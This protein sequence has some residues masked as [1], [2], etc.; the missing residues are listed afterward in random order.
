MSLSSSLSIASSGLSALQAELA[1]ASQ[2]V[3]NAGTAGYAKETA[4]VSSRTSGGQPGGVLTGLTG[5]VVDT[6]LEASLYAQNATVAALIATNTNLAPILALQG[7]TS[8]LPGI[9]GTLSD[10]VGNLQT[11]LISLEAD[12]TN[13]AGQQAVL[14]AAGSLASNIRTTA[15][16]YQT[17]RQTAQD[18]ALDDVATANASLASIGS[19]SDRIA[20]GRITGISTADLENQRAVAMTSLSNVLSVQFKET[21]N[22]DM[23]VSTANGL[24]LPTRS[25]EGPLATSDATVTVSSVYPDSIPAITLDGR[26]VTS[27]LTGG[28]LGANIVLRD[29]TLPT[30]QAELDSF[31][32]TLASRFDSQG[33][34]LFTDGSGNLPGS[35]GTGPS[36]AGQVGF[37][38]VIQVNPAVS[39][40]P[41]IVRDGSHDVTGTTTGA[42]G[43]TVNAGRGTAD[44]TLID[45]LLDF[46]LGAQVQ[47]GVTQP[48]ASSTGLGLNGALSSPYS[49]GGSLTS[50]AST[51]TGAQA[52][53]INQVTTGLASE[54]VIQTSL[55]AKVASVSGVSVDD[56]MSSIVALQNA[57]AANAKV[58]A[59]VQSM[60]SALLN[61]TN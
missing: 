38:N 8:S 44:T 53:T 20:Q 48:S 12:P 56:E 41:S 37:A 43:F 4:S 42:S 19:L 7:S 24:S 57:Y 46:T 26:D 51:L 6:A 61:A 58:I 9:S 52:S 3:A 27:S 59:A 54:T 2:N 60:F 34:T 28:A 29:T 47:L 32:Q 5:R 50:L 18:A 23:L 55:G 31:S 39:A 13:A 33:L 35:G 10:T 49:G 36:P 15:N 16:A 21:A 40:N 1:V 45:R 22:G 11:S 17:Q 25:T 30:M 14:A